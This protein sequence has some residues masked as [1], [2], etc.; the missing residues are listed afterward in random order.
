MWLTRYPRP[1]EI[2]Y[3]QGKGFIGNYFRKSPIET[4]YGITDKPRT[5]RNTN[6]N[7]ILERINQALANLVRTFNIKENYFD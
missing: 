5:S 7:E 1:M 6:P 2:M 3:D 4:E